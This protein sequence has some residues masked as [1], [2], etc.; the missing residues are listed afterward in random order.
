MQ[1]LLDDYQPSLPP[2]A[3]TAIRT[4]IGKRADLFKEAV[5]TQDVKAER[6]WAVLVLLSALETQISFLL[7][8]RFEIRCQAC[9]QRRQFPDGAAPASRERG[10]SSRLCCVV[11][12]ATMPVT[13][14][15]GA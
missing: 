9:S 2:A 15:M 13:N 4:F 6:G 11:L 1:R 14:F 12:L 3:V 7:R 10:V 5:E 8:G